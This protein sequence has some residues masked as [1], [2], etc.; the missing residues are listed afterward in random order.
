MATMLH[1]SP[2][3]LVM[4]HLSVIVLTAAM[5][6]ALG[7]LFLLLLPITISVPLPLSTYR[8]IAGYNKK[9]KHYRNH[10]VSRFHE[11]P[12]LDLSHQGNQISE[13]PTPRAGTPMS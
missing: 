8:R 7:L 2:L 13:P 11:S 9:S 4:V 5:S 12:R 6:T 3:S 10:E 1:V